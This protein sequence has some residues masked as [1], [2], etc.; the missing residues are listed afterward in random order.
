MTTS[1]QMTADGGHMAKIFAGS[2]IKLSGLLAG[3]AAQGRPHMRFGQSPWPR[4]V[5]DL[6]PDHPAIRASSQA[7]MIAQ[8]ITR[9][10]LEIFDIFSSVWLFLLSSSACCNVF[11][12]LSS[13][14]PPTRPS[15]NSSGGLQA[16]LFHCQLEFMFL[17]GL[18]DG[19]TPLVL[20]RSQAI[21]PTVC[22]EFG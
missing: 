8:T 15:E 19:R 6:V 9:L 11:P 22:V 12:L 7:E 16:S 3:S 4:S 14:A 21:H 10:G 5:A 2:A 18:T 13:P 17:N 1:V 20:Q